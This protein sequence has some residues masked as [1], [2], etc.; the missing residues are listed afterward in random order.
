VDTLYLALAA[1]LEITIQ[2]AQSYELTCL[3]NETTLDPSM[4]RQSLADVVKPTKGRGRTI[5]FVASKMAILSFSFA[6][7]PDS[8]SESESDASSD[9]DS[10]YTDTDSESSGDS[11][12]TDSTESSED[13]RAVRKTA[14]FYMNH[15]HDDYYDQID[16]YREDDHI[17]V[18]YFYDR[19]SRSDT[20]AS[21]NTFHGSIVDAIDHMNHVFRMMAV[22]RKPY[23]EVEVDIPF[24]PAMSQVPRDFLKK[25][26]RAMILVA[27][28]EF[29]EEGLN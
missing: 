5:D 6:V 23:R 10:D 3:G 8:D 1:Y 4:G 25:A 22:D 29:L 27:L 9:T 21:S 20:A 28:K 26:R 15:D 16:L 14:R 2:E 17:R 11:E 12:S 19:R 7:G 24:F 13:V 18:D